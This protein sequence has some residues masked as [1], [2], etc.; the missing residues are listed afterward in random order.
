[1]V[2]S[3]ATTGL[4]LLHRLVRQA[5]RRLVTAGPARTLPRSFQYP[6]RS[7]VVVEARCLAPCESEQCP[8]SVYMSELLMRSSLPDF[9]ESKSVQDH[10]H[11]SWLQN[12]DGHSSIHL[13]S[14]SAHELGFMSRFTVFEQHGNH[15]AHILPQFVQ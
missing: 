12:G 3:D 10:Y 1:M 9:D 14:F 15:L 13:N 4:R 2:P 11:L 5:I 7:F 8:A 6:G